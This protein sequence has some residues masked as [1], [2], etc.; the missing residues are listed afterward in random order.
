VVAVEAGLA[1]PA[2]F[3]PSPRH[4]KT[5]HLD[6]RVRDEVSWESIELK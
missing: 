6:L 3:H 1:K 4:V 2:L 5:L